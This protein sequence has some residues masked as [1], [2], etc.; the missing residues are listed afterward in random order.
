MEAAPPLVGRP[1][2]GG[3]H[4]PGTEEAA[5]E[6]ARPRSSDTIHVASLQPLASVAPASQGLHAYVPRRVPLA[7]RSKG[8]D[9]LPL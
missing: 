4:V 5:G 2:G 6:A 7:S 1:W 9:W 3:C 8:R